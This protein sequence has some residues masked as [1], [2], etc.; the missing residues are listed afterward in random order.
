MSGIATTTGCRRLVE[1][2]GSA[3]C[4][5]LEHGSRYRD[6]RPVAQRMWQTIMDVLRD[7]GVE[8]LAA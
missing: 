7:I 6:K 1:S 5:R 8:G 2:R 4:E 3:S